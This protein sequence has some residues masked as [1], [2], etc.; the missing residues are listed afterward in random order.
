MTLSFKVKNQNG[1]FKLAKINGS[2]KIH[3]GGESTPDIDNYYYN[4]TLLMHFNDSR[5]GTYDPYGDYVSLLMHMDGTN[6]QTFFSNSDSSKYNRE[7]TR[8]GDTK[9]SSERAYFGTTSAY[10]DGTGDYLAV[11]NASDMSFGTGDFTVELWVNVP[12]LGRQ[13]FIFGT[14]T[15]GNFMLQLDSDGRMWLG[16]HY[17]LWDAQISHGI[18]E[19]T[20]THIAVT[21]YQGTMRFF[22]NGN[23]IGSPFTNTNTYPIDNL[24][25]G[26]HY[27]STYF[28]GYMDDIRITNGI[29]R[30]TSN[31]PIPT[32]AFPQILPLF[33]D[34][35]AY[36]NPFI[37]SSTSIS[38][39]SSKFGGYAGYFNGSSFLRSPGT[40]IWQLGT[41]DFTVESWFNPNNLTGRKSIVGNYDG[42]NGGWGLSVKQP[43][44]GTPSYGPEVS[45][46]KSNY[47]SEVDVIIPG[48]LEITRGN[49]QGIYNAAL[50]SGYNHNSSPLNTS[51]NRCSGFTDYGYY[52]Y[53]DSGDENNW[54]NICNYRA[55]TYGDW[56]KYAA[57]RYP[58]SMVGKELI[59]KHVPTNRYWLIKFTSWQAYAQGG[60]F[61]YTRKEILNCSVDSSTIQFRYGDSS[62]IEKSTSGVIP[63]GTWSHVAAVRSSGV[64]KLF[65]DGNQIG[66]SETFTNNIIRNNSYGLSI[67]AT[68]L[69]NGNSSDY[70]NGYLDDLR[71]TKGVARYIN[72]FTVPSAP[73]ENIGPS[74]SVPSEPLNLTVSEDLG[75]VSLSWNK[76]TLPSAIDTRSPISYYA[77]E[78]SNNDG[79]SWTESSFTTSV[80]DPYFSSV[81]ALLN[82]DGMGSTFTDLSL[83]PKTITSIGGASQ[84]LEQS[85][86][87]SKS[88]YLN[89]NGQYLI[90]N[91]INRLSGDFAI[92]FWLR[93]ESLG[94]YKAIVAGS[95]SNTQVFISSRADGHGLRGGLVGIAEYATGS[96]TWLI[97]TWYHVALSRTSGVWKF[98]VNGADVT[99]GQFT[100]T[101]T[102]GGEMRIGAAEN[103]AANP[104][105][106]IDDFRVTVGSNRGYTGN[107]IAVPTSPFFSNQ[108][109]LIRNIGGLP[110]NTPYLFRVR[111]QN[112]IGFGNYSSIA[113]ISTLSN[114]PSG[115]NAIPDNSQAFVSWTAPTPNNSAIRDYAIQYSSD[116]GSSWTTFP[117]SSSTN[118]LI[119]ITGLNNGSNYVFRVAAVNLAGTG[120]YS[121]YNTGNIGGGG[122]GSSMPV[123]GGGGGGDSSSINVAPRSDNLYNKTRILLHLDSN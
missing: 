78:Y 37:V 13:N 109:S 82:M 40:D 67:G 41:D 84:S 68:T 27:F 71:I 45:F 44:G 21:R 48:V 69:S 20:W 121:T 12:N 22:V 63:T 90:I 95:S 36:N 72:S 112:S 81:A 105:A 30:Y 7:V 115:V 102:F 77:V 3:I 99:D 94:S 110:D 87:G 79:S 83:S 113:N 119:N 111:A 19:N 114:A 122:G 123:G 70:F 88:L 49:N 91:N 32:E 4:N 120:V 64:L 51:W 35:S 43:S 106:Y 29:A 6:N 10:F 53:C 57:T 9:L 98:Y 26:M 28:N 85:K 58:S 66:T 116:V 25:I 8:Y 33:V 117:H 18:Q 5:T 86:W 107:T 75:I 92:E 108:V 74:P 52:G 73:F 89:G 14:N 101:T 17:I 34:S 15:T 61:S 80:P 2:Y 65:L 76:P 50:E 11:P 46:T 24:Y 103:G 54:N 93:W 38:S 100:N 1:N 97:N 60:G 104:N 55:R 42:S 56:E 16:R 118:T 23:I 31:F 59:M 47:G 62:V 39:D 96:Y